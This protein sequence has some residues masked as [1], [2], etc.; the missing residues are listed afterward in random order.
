M[1]LPPGQHDHIIDFDWDNCR[2]LLKEK[3][4][5]LAAYRYREMMKARGKRGHN[6]DLDYEP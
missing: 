1:T 2:N 3:M 5:G 6:G 4:Q